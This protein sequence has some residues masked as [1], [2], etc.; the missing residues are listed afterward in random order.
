MCSKFLEFFPEE[1]LNAERMK[2]ESTPTVWL[3]SQQRVP[4]PPQKNLFYSSFP[5]L[6]KRPPTVAA[7]GS[8]LKGHSIDWLNTKPNLDKRCV[9]HLPLGGD[10]GKG[11]GVVNP[12]LS[13]RYCYDMSE[14]GHTQI[15]CCVNHFIFPIKLKPA[16]KGGTYTPFLGNKFI[17]L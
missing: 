16:C 8:S 6:L 13:I 17:L 7:V 2:G 5:H 12:M 4:L 14:I 3:R 9:L 10:F 11:L 1:V 15:S